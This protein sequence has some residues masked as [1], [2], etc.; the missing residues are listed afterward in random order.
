MS[1][2]ARDI[3]LY[4]FPGSN[5]GL[6]AELIL[7]HANVAHER[8]Q[9]R[10]G[11]HAASLKARGFPAATVP[12]LYV[13]GTRLNGSR[14]IAHLVADELAPDSQLLPEDAELRSRVLEVER[15]GE[16]LQ[17]A[18][19]R[20]FYAA[21]TS[22]SGGVRNLVDANFS[23]LPGLV[24]TAVTA[25]L[26]PAARM[27]HKIRVE[28]G[29]SYV[30]RV[31]EL[32]RLADEYVEAG[33]LGTDTPNVA[34]FQFAPNVVVLGEL[35]GAFGEIVRAHRVWEPMLRLLPKYPI[36]FTLALPADWLGDAVAVDQQ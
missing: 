13:D 3:R 22:S 21:A 30:A 20:A 24:R 10:P 23:D 1:T 16:R 26:I 7:D 25:A 15:D 5:A 9:L 14:Q 18:V 11:L 32:L 17:N 36:T 6:T 29:P 34:D 2:D 12:A 31:E 33:L 35:E 19:R 27:G 4:T 28:Q 8:V